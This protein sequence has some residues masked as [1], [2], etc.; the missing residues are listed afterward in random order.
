MTDQEYYNL[1]VAIIQDSENIIWRSSLSLEGEIRISDSIIQFIETAYENGFILYNKIS[2]FN[3]NLDF[4]DIYDCMDKI[5]SYTMSL[6]YQIKMSL[7]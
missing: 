2:E 4:V 1:I 7:L 6:K 5:L 3:G